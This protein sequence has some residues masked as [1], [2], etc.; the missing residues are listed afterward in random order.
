MHYFET[1]TGHNFH[2]CKGIWL[3]RGVLPI[4]DEVRQ[5]YEEHDRT[6]KAG[7]DYRAAF[8]CQT[9]D[10]RSF[11]VAIGLQSQFAPSLYVRFGT[12]TGKMASGRNSAAVVA[13]IA[14]SGH[15]E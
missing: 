4:A 14:K 15:I 3:S 11:A 7:E 2:I 13:N 9:G 1:C 8:V 12:D 10:H 5:S 6:C